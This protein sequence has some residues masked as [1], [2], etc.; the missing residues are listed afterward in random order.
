MSESTTTHPRQENTEQSNTTQQSGSNKEE[1]YKII[2]EFVPDLLHTFPEYKETLH[3]GIIDILQESYDSNACLDVYD[4]CLEVYPSRFF[5][6]L[7]QNADA[8]TEN[9]DEP[10]FFLPNIDFK[11]LWAS[12][13]S[14]KTRDVIWKYLQ[15]ILFSVLGD[16]NHEQ[17][18]G[19]TA[20]LFEAIN[21]DELKRKL[22]KT[23]EDMQSLF[24]NEDGT[25][26]DGANINMDQLPTP[27]SI[28]DHL[29]GMLGGKLGN[30]AREIAEETA[31]ELNMDM[32]NAGSVNDVFQKMFKNPGKLMNMVKNIGTKIETKIKSGEIKE[33]ELMKEASEMMSKMNDIPGMGNIKSMLKQFGLP[34][35]KGK[36]N[37]GAFQSHM[38]QNMKQSKMR[39]RMQERLAKKQQQQEATMS[40]EQRAYL[41][42]MARQAQE[43]LLA[44]EVVEKTPRVKKSK[45]SKKSKKAKKAKNVVE[46]QEES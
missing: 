29:N 8:F 30:L 19:D 9:K 41:E 2:R 16:V 20:K 22:E 36:V 40:D 38:A 7:Y 6:I 26:V 32:E 15:L 23:M 12:D 17:S 14:D 45:K 1:F 4:H 3:E 10:L 35:G 42:Q 24:Q 28:H 18:F 21:E 37:M 27:E 43:E 33:S 5:D 34:V 25:P 44:M 39:E 13:V 46:V 31:Q 11:Q